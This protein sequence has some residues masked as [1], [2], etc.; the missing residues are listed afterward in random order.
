MSA[1]VR[2]L[3]KSDSI[4]KSYAQMKESSFLDSQC[5]FMSIKHIGEN[6]DKIIPCS[7]LNTGGI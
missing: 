4:C 3:L 7:A 6:C 5:S 2:E 1:T